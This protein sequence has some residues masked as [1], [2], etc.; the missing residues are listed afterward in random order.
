MDKD[1][2]FETKTQRD[3]VLGIC[4]QS[5]RLAKGICEMYGEGRMSAE[6]VSGKC[7]TTERRIRSGQSEDPTG[8]DSPQKPHHG[9]PFLGRRVAESACPKSFGRFDAQRYIWTSVSATAANQI[10]RTPTTQFSS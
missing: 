1:R 6:K 4:R 3:L 7:T 8:L 5:S 9:P 10:L 2:D